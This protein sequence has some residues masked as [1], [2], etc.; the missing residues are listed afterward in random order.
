MGIIR[1]DLVR[2]R[3]NVLAIVVLGEVQL[4]ELGAFERRARDR[5]GAVLLEPGQDVGQVE[6]GAVGR[7]DWMRKRLQR[8][9]AEFEGKPL[10]R[11]ARPLGFAQAGASAGRVGVFRRPL[12]VGDV[13]FVGA[14]G[15]S[16]VTPLQEPAAVTFPHD[17]LTTCLWPAACVAAVSEES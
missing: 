11:G 9:G 6:D 4:D 5:V 8:D 14:C 15:G 17:G 16:S 3:I 10:E 7:A 1:E 13:E 12:R 2:D